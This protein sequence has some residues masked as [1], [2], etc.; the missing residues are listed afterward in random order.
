M[1]TYFSKNIKNKSD[2]EKSEIYS[3]LKAIPIGSFAT[4]QWNCNDDTLYGVSY[5][6]CDNASDNGYIWHYEPIEILLEDIKAQL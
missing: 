2:Y 3:E 1:N 4:I 6:T 5:I